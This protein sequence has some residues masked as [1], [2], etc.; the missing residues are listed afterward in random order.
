VSLAAVEEAERKQAAASAEYTLACAELNKAQWLLG[1]HRE[2]RAVARARSSMSAEVVA[3]WLTIFDSEHPHPDS[4][5]TKTLLRR[6]LLEHTYPGAD[7]LTP[8]G[9]RV[10]TLLRAEVRAG[11]LDC[12]GLPAAQDIQEEPQ[13]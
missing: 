11:T 12:H 5:V 10:L 13:R 3:A 6:K 2:E 1:E 9:R 8:R 4:P 7:R